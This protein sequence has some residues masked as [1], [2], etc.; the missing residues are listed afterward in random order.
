MCGNLI[1]FFYD[2]G[3]P[4]PAQ[5]QENYR[6]PAAGT[7][8]AWGVASSGAPISYTAHGNRDSA[9]EPRNENNLLIGTWRPMGGIGFRLARA[10]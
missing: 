7:W 10:R 9:T 2:W 1:Q 4:A 3:G 6:G 5:A 8:K